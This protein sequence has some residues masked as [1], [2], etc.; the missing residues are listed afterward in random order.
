MELQAPLRDTQLKSARLRVRKQSGPAKS[1]SKV[2]LKSPD[3]GAVAKDLGE[4]G[5]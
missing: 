2:A 1:L 3:S 5:L 4:W